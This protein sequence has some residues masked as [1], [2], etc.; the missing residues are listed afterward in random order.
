MAPAKLTQEDT[1]ASKKQD[2]LEN[3][4]LALGCVSLGAYWPEYMDALVSL[5]A[6]STEPEILVCSKRLRD[7]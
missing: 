7:Q 2:I 1:I 3:A 5:N 6:R 4:L